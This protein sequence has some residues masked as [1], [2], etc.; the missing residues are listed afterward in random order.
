MREQPVFHYPFEGHPAPIPRIGLFAYSPFVLLKLFGLAAHTSFAEL[1]LTN[2]FRRLTRP[3]K[4]PLRETSLLRI[5]N[6]ILEKLG[7]GQ[8]VP[9]VI[10]DLQLAFAGCPD[11]RQRVDNMSLTEAF[12]LGWG[13]EPSTWQRR[14]CHQVVLERA[15]WHVQRLLG[16]GN[17]PLAASFMAAHPLLKHLLWP[18]ALMELRSAHSH[19]GLSILTGQMALD[20]H[21]G[22]LAAWDLDDSENRGLEAPQFECLLFSATQPGR[23]PTSLL[24]DELQRRMRVSTV[25]EVLD[26][27]LA[28]LK[29]GLGTLYRWSSGKYFP[30]QET[31][32]EL[33]AAHGL[34]DPKDILRRQFN[35][36]KLIN[37]LGFI[38]QTLAR[39]V[40]E[41]SSPLVPG[42]R[43]AYPFGHSDFASWA[44]T[45]Y[46]YWLAYH[47]EHGETL[48]SLA[49]AAAHGPGDR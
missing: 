8:D 32:A 43:T 26:G 44:A 30:D 2:Q 21:L 33:M 4:G 42:P 29:V 48:A 49:K 39:A 47:R 31:F 9:S 3:K 25:A 12:F 41:E 46:P 37:L 1:G 24:F 27:C 11:A 22:W 19:E 23:N 28:P 6:E 7:T 13:L 45:R 34:V 17:G 18:D 20:A 5:L 35:A 14:H 15:G 16:A 36:T 38:G 10:R 40:R